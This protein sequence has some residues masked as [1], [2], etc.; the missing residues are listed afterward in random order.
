MKTLI[1][2]TSKKL[3]VTQI[4]MFLRCPVQWEFRYI[5][6]I[7]TPPAGVM[8]QGRVYHSTHAENFRQKINTGKDL[9]LS[10]MSDI[11]A[12]SWNKEVVNNSEYSFSEIT[13]DESPGKVKDGGYDLVKLYRNNMAPLIIPKEVEI[14]K[15]KKISQNLEGMG[16]LDLVIDKLNTPNGS[17]ETSDI[18]GDL[19]IDHKVSGRKQTQ[20]EAERDLQATMYLWL[21]D[22]D[23]FEFHR[24]I[25]KQKPEIQIVK[26]KRTEEQFN[27]MLNMIKQIHALMK[28]GIA[29]PR[30]DSFWCSSNFCGYYA[31]CKARLNV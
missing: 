22:S 25:R 28:L 12:T 5:K 8:L 1:D 4:N 27:R 14:R 18:I 3:S 30:C 24:A 11:Y 20:D 10:D 15:S 31:M 13:W 21:T 23:T 9:S 17:V 7:K 16:I 2:K 19:I 26:T 29:F 6:H